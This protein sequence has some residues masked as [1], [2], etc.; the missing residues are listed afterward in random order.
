MATGTEEYFG[1]SIAWDT[2]YDVEKRYWLG[3]GSIVPPAGDN[4]RAAMIH[5]IRER[6]FELESE[7]RGYVLR[8]AKEWADRDRR[9]VTEGNLGAIRPRLDAFEKRHYAF[10][11]HGPYIPSECDVCWLIQT[12]RKLMSDELVTRLREQMAESDRLR[13]ELAARKTQDG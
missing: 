12:A 9:K 1:Y 5:A 4:G 7:A 3:T 2:H 6:E 11:D 8:V 10:V 13:K